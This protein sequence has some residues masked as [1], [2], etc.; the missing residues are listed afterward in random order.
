M[1]RRLL[2]THH[3]S[4][5][6]RHTSHVTRHTSHVTRHTSHVTRHMSHV[7]RHTS[8]TRA[9]Q[10][11]CLNW[12]ESNQTLQWLGLAFN[13]FVHVIM[14]VTT[15][16]A[17]RAPATLPF[18]IKITPLQLLHSHITLTTFR[19][20][21]THHV[22]Y[23]Y[24]AFTTYRPAPRPLKLL[25]T[26]VRSRACPSVSR[27]RMRAMPVIAPCACAPLFFMLS[28]DTNRA[29]CSI[30]RHIHGHFVSFARICTA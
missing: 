17:A 16:N 4:H 24:Y 8:L 12:I 14:S 26:Q 9:C 19:L 30:P 20:S 21:L 13:T 10:V 18:L 1:V 3:T 29:V 6:T 15:N 25:I 2:V 5:V 23:A 7:T 27:R 22:R 28:P 11:M